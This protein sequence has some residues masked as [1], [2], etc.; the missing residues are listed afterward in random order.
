MNAPHLRLL[1]APSPT[2]RWIAAVRREATSG[3]LGFLT[4]PTAV[5]VT[6]PTSVAEWIATIRREGPAAA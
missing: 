5:R 3:D 1:P 2:D 4:R 6:P